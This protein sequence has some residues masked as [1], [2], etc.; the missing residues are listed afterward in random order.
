MGSPESTDD[1]EPAKAPLEDEN[2]NTLEEDGKPEDQTQLTDGEEV[3]IAYPRIQEL[4]TI[5][6][7]AELAS[8]IN[9]YQILDSSQR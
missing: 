1:K 7:E 6:E 8:L 2:D 5:G 3:D 4:A 9:D